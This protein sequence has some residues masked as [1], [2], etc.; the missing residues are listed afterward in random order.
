MDFEE[1]VKRINQADMILSPDALEFLKK[2]ENLEDLVDKLLKGNDFVITAER[3]SSLVI[4]SEEKKIPLPVEVIRSSNF[5]AVAAEYPARLSVEKG[6]D[7]SGKSRCVGNV[8]D[9][10][11]YFR[12]RFRETEK[13]FRSRVH[14]NPTATTKSL[15]GYGNGARVRL[16]GIINSKRKTKKGHLLIEIE[17]EHGSAKVL[18]LDDRKEKQHSCFEKAN[19]LLLDEVVGVDGRISD[20]FLIAEDIVW[21]DL[22]V[23][24]QKIGGEEDLSIAFLSDIHFGSRYFLEKNFAHMTQWLNGGAGNERSREAAGKV[25]YVV[26]AGDIVD[27]VGVYPKQE[28]ELIV[29]D[30]YEQYSL[31]AKFLSE[32]P[33]YIEVVVSPGNHDAVRRAEPQPKLSEEIMGEACNMTN[34]HPIG[35]PTYVSIADLKV[36][37]YHGTS[38]DS[39]IA[40]TQGCD[41]LHPEKP[42]LELMK[43]RHLSPIY[44]DNPIVPEEKDYL[45]ISELPDIVHMGHVH[46]NG[47]MLYRG[48]SLVNSG[49]WQGRT[50]FQ[51][52][53]GH[54]PSPCIMPVY[55]LKTGKMRNFDFSVDGIET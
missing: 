47:Y 50:D 20:P 16:V 23:K 19:T 14:T 34:V 38:L 7:V 44:G 35:N 39:I 24:E 46:K 30:V 5:K 18:A 49:T 11:N 33:D 45:V 52:K 8:E 43:R 22:P 6:S 1:A 3:I 27:G 28:N 4:K 31:L 17:D 2:A 40:A 12:S 21:P 36:L 13:I 29:K 9:F 26:I 53:Q 48:V 42:M 10:V 51:V 41:Y 54:V 37:V 15:A 55:E 32:L 25:K